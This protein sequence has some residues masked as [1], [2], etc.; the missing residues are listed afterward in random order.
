MLQPITISRRATRAAGS[1]YD[2]APFGVDPGVPYIV[3][4]KIRALSREERLE[5]EGYSVETDVRIFLVPH[6]PNTAKV[7]VGDRITLRGDHFAVQNVSVEFRQVEI[8]ASNTSSRG[9]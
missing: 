8:E 2:S 1:A 4:A 3:G 7:Q 6:T 9:S 5:G